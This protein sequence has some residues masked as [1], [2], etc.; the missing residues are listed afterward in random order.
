MRKPR[1]VA[2]D[3]AHTQRT[4][5]LY[6]LAKGLPA[7][8]ATPWTSRNPKEIWLTQ[9]AAPRFSRVGLKA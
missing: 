4:R 2:P 8:R 6:R 1:V 9:T 7:G 5:S 3:L